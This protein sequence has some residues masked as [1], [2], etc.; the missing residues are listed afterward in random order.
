[1]FSDVPPV[2]W[3]ENRDLYFPS[4]I[5]PRRFIKFRCFAN[6]IGIFFFVFLFPP[7][8]FF[9]DLSQPVVYQSSPRR[10][11]RSSFFRLFIYRHR[12][13]ACSIDLLPPLPP[14]GR[15]KDTSAICL[16]VHTRKFIARAFAYFHFTLADASRRRFISARAARARINHFARQWWRRQSHPAWLT[17]GHSFQA[18]LINNPSISKA[19]VATHAPL[20]ECWYTS[21]WCAERRTDRSFSRY[22]SDNHRTANAHRPTDLDHD[23]PSPS[24]VWFS[25]KSSNQATATGRQRCTKTG[26]PSARA[27]SSSYN[28]HS[29]SLEFITSACTYTR[30][31]NTTQ[32]NREIDIYV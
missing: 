21:W 3:D 20:E 19:A 22:S 6:G 23:R 28:N 7:D 25:H 15:T 5:S 26:L 12:H 29:Y 32:H 10:A 8:A 11:A 13:R 17:A 18:G 9:H 27:F 16:F 2:P 31:H 14:S 24:S 30:I 4:W 1:M